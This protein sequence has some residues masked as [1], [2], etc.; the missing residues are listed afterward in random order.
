MDVVVGT[1]YAVINAIRKLR[2]L[3]ILEVAMKFSSYS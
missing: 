3:C 1:P 2:T